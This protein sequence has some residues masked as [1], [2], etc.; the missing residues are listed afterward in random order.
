MK[1]Q[2]LRSYSVSHLMNPVEGRN[3]LNMLGGARA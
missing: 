2:S 1:L 3:Q